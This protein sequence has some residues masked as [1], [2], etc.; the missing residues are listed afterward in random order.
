MNDF[1][2][3]ARKL[4]AL[5]AT[6][7]HP[8]TPPGEK[9]AAQARIE[10]LC[11]RHGFTVADILAT[12]LHIIEIFAETL[13]LAQL[14][15]QLL[16][17]IA[18]KDS[19][20]ERHISRYDYVIPSKPRLTK[21]GKPKFTRPKAATGYRISALMPQVEGDDWKA[22][23]AHY[24]PILNASIQTLDTQIKT[25]R[26]AR[27]QALPGLCNQF[28]LFPE[29]STPGKAPKNFDMAAY[30][31]AMNAAQGE[32]WQGNTAKLTDTFLLKA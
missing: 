13:E 9:Q 8:E 32:R 22:A 7:A 12:E 1:D 5:Q 14:A 18:G 25:A 27:K 23:Y 20:A 3:I 29:D 15:C 10:A 31:A 19:H 11:Q 2:S 26:K 17:I 28:H 16:R 30:I 4:R 21:N 24:K 6:V